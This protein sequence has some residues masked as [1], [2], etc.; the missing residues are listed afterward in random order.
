M[1]T[2]AL[3]RR[4]VLLSL[5]TM[6]NGGLVLAHTA[7]LPLSVSLQDELAQALQKQTPLVVMI[8]LAGCPFCKM[9]REN[10][11][12]PMHSQQGLSVVQV[13]MHSKRELKNFSGTSL[14]HEDLR[15]TWGI[16]IAPTLLFFGRNGTEIAPRLVGASI[17]DFYGAY[18]DERLQQA[19]EAIK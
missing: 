10:Y 8:S 11:L 7:S 1:N 19:Q 4:R 14:S 17:P 3:T 6:C 2:R 12:A 9:I 18:L 15:R 13:D 16:K 5:G